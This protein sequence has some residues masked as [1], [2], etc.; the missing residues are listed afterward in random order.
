MLRTRKNK[1]YNEETNDDKGEGGR[2]YNLKDKIR[3]PRF[4]QLRDLQ[5]LPGENVS[6]KLIQRNGFEKPILVET[7]A[8]LDLRVPPKSFIVRDVGKLV[9]QDRMID[10][11]DVKTQK[12]IEMTMKEWCKYYESRQRDRLL[13]VISL[14]FSHTDLDDLVDSPKIVKHLDWVDLVWPKFLKQSQTESTNTIDKMKYPKVQKYCLMSVK[15]SYTDFHIDFGGTSVWYHILRGKKMFWMCPPTELN[16]QAFEEWT[17]S[18]LQQDVFFG[19][20]VE[21][22]FRVELSAG[23]TFFIPSGWIH[24]VYTVEDSL[25]FGGNFLHSFGIENQLK[26]SRIE[27][28]T[29]VPLKFRYPFYTEILWYVVQHYVYCLTGKSHLHSTPMT[30]EKNVQ[31][32]RE[33]QRTI[34]CTGETTESE[35]DES[36]NKKRVF[37]R[38]RGRPPKVAAARKSKKSI[39]DDESTEIDSDFEDVKPNKITTTCRMT[40]NSLLRLQYEIDDS[41]NRKASNETVNGNN[42]KAKKSAKKSVDSNGNE[43]QALQTDLAVSTEGNLSNVTQVNV[44]QD[45]ARLNGWTPNQTASHQ[46]I[47]SNRES[48]SKEPTKIHITKFEVNGLRILVKHL[49][50]LSGVKKNLPALIRNSRALLDDC[51]KLIAEHEN[52]DPELAATDVP[53]GPDLLNPKKSDINQL[54]EQFFKPPEVNANDGLSVLDS[55]NSHKTKSDSTTLTQQQRLKYMQSAFETKGD[56]KNLAYVDAKMPGVS[57]PSKDTKTPSPNKKCSTSLSPALAACVA[58]TSSSTTAQPRPKSPPTRPLSN[59]QY[60]SKTKK[61]NTLVLPSSFADL[62]AATSTAKELFDVSS[63][64][65]TSSLFGLKPSSPNKTIPQAQK[66]D[67]TTSVEIAPSKS[68]THHEDKSQATMPISIT[69]SMSKPTLKPP[70]S[71]EPPKMPSTKRFINPSYKP[72]NKEK[73]VFASA[74]YVS[75]AHNVE[76]SK[77]SHLYPWQSPAPH[78]SL[79]QN[80]QRQN[81]PSNHS[82]LQAPLSY[83]DPH[84]HITP[85][86]SPEPNKR[87]SIVNQ[88]VPIKKELIHNSVIGKMDVSICPINSIHDRVKSNREKDHA[89]SKDYGRIDSI[90]GASYIMESIPKDRVNNSLS[91]PSEDSNTESGP[92]N[93]VSH[94]KQH[95]SFAIDRLMVPSVDSGEVDKSRKPNKPRG[96]P[97][98]SKEARQVLETESSNASTP[99]SVIV[100]GRQPVVTSAESSMIDTQLELPSEKDKPKVKRSKKKKDGTSPSNE[101][102]SNQTSS[103]SAQFRPQV[104]YGLVAPPTT[105]SANATITPSPK[106]NPQQY[107][108]SRPLLLN[109]MPTFCTSQLQQP[110]PQSALPIFTTP[111]PTSMGLA[112]MQPGTRIVWATRPPASTIPTTATANSSIIGQPTSYVKPKAE[113]SSSTIPQKQSDHAALLSLATT[114]LST[115]PLPTTP[116]LSHIGARG[117]TVSQALMVNPMVAGQSALFAGQQ[118]LNPFLSRMPLIGQPQLAMGAPNQVMANI[119]P[120]T[121][122]PRQSGQLLFAPLPG[123]TGQPRYLITQPGFLSHR[124]QASPLFAGQPTPT[125]LAFAAY[126]PPVANTSKAESVKVK[127]VK[128]R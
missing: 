55:P 71:P 116:T 95:P 115:A 125:T 54:I 63:A 52:D 53:V 38:K 40:K 5:V 111:V 110:M 13:N 114:A 109:S 80:P 75:P 51:K 97:K 94:P 70:N 127:K 99:V 14:E 16:L 43:F 26:V 79:P 86:P 68:Q 18:G 73:L 6:L 17:L 3:S 67:R 7:P 56:K 74:P 2:T 36:D 45:V 108:I 58:A 48:E 27:D 90:E 91:S 118:F 20:T 84:Q 126:R 113:E 61:D 8:G 106:M 105:S 93:E 39:T 4:E 57:S 81:Q 28:A 65:V 107:L 88:Q 78:L 96:P 124:P 112:S 128:T 89:A 49:S 44:S 31:K 34:G 69:E 92:S 120:K 103:N 47:W 82:S 1:R 23:N 24:A 21:E 122:V 72:Q 29:K 42:S 15:G 85:S 104:I 12:N 66:R 101:L 46:L 9:G 50:K 100:T 41:V 102:I 30:P 62:I 19:D 76:H 98:K 60:T 87:S 59:K 11:M 121:A 25:V 10:V 117:T 119:T 37:P 22:C 32:S 33:K 123:Q 64:D 83:Q 35:Q 77:N